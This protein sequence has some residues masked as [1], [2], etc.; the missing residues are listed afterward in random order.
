[1]L[2]KYE[3]LATRVEA[4]YQRVS[5]VM[6]LDKSPRNVADEILINKPGELYSGH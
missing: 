1:L 2:K 6:L 3:H 5:D 4:K